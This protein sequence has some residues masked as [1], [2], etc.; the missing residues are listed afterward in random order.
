MLSSTGSRRRRCVVN[1]ATAATQITSERMR[2]YRALCTP[3]R[4][5]AAWFQPQTAAAAAL[6]AELSRALLWGRSP[7]WELTRAGANVKGRMKGIG[8]WSGSQGSQVLPLLCH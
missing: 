6:P 1:T 3:G 7:S 4:E 2:P 5:Q 8:Q